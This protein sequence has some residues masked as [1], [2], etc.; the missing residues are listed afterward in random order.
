MKIPGLHIAGL[1]WFQRS[2]GNT[3]HSVTVYRDG[4]EPWQ[5]GIHYGYGDMFLQTAMAYLARLGLIEEGD[6]HG[7]RYLR[8]ELG[9][10]YSVSDVAR[11]RDLK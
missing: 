10:T 11:E 9:G 4:A 1:R 2:Y 6:S 5:S 7:T 3:Y 8:E